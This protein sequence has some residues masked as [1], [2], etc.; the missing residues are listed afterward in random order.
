LKEG[1]SDPQAHL[2]LA[3]TDKL[4]TLIE[5]QPY[6]GHS[7]K[8]R[9]RQLRRPGIDHAHLDQVKILVGIAQ[10]LKKMPE[11]CG[12][13]AKLTSARMPDAL[14]LN[15]YTLTRIDAKKIYFSDF[16]RKAPAR[17]GLDE[18]LLTSSPG[19]RETRHNRS[20]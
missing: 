5:S 2:Y 19:H 20:E 4:A 11:S 13:F 7:R 14:P 18:E 10:R 17:A 1:I 12:I 16:A 15:R 8:V 3:A 9:T 6:R